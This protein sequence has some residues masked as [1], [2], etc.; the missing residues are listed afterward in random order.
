YR[1]QQKADQVLMA[2]ERRRKV[3]QN[4]MQDVR[5]SYWRALG[6]QK[7]LGRADALL[8][9]VNKALAYARQIEEQGLMPRQEVL[10]YQRALLDAVNLL[11]LRRQDLELACIE[12]SALMSVAPG[13]SY[14]LADEAEQPLPPVPANLE[15]LETMALERRPEI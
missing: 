13:T 12:L 11:T 14:T 15:L 2:Q 3:I 1:A 9:R 6:A 5:N 10:A 7:L 4:V 8:D